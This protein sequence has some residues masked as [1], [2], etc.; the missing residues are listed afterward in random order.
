[1]ADVHTKVLVSE[2]I[3][4]LTNNETAKRPIAI[5]N[6]KLATARV[7]EFVKPANA[8]FGVIHSRQLHSR[9]RL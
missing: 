2:N 5:A 1:M 6:R 3:V 7:I 9:A 4:A 8:N